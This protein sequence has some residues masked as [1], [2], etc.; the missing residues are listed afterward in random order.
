MT[1]Y[2]LPSD[3]STN[4]EGDEEGIG[5][6]M[7]GFERECKVQERIACPEIGY[8]YSE[9]IYFN[10]KEWEISTRQKWEDICNP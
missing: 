5:N 9:A 7:L 4:E 3:F 1:K 8:P 10:I 2:E 6:W